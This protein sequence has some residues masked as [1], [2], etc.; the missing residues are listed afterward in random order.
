MK[1]MDQNLEKLLE[2]LIFS[3]LFV[4]LELANFENS[5]DSCA[6]WKNKKKD[7]VSMEVIQHIAESTS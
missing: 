2:I 3:R 6:I 1:K 7:K 5:L 4:Q